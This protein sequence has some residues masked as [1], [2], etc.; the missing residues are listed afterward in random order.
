MTKD[1]KIAL[2]HDLWKE[3]NGRCPY[4]GTKM[5]ANGIHKPRRGSRQATIEHIVPRSMGG[6]DDLKNLTCS[7]RSCDS[8]R[9]SLL[10]EDFLIIRKYDDWM[11]LGTFT[12]HH[13]YMLTP[14]VMVGFGMWKF[15]RWLK[16]QKS[17][18]VA[19]NLPALAAV[20]YIGCIF[21]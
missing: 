19:R 1:Q 4:C 11:K 10:H 2:R 14:T 18:W 13:R 16:T 9:G 7:C 5:W 12:R 20:S 8:G 21:T 6:T 17:R 3:V 15:C